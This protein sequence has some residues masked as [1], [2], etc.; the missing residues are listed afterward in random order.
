M[1]CCSYMLRD[2]NFAL[3]KG[4]EYSEEDLKFPKSTEAR[5]LL[6]GSERV[7]AALMLLGLFRMAFF[8]EE[9]EVEE[10]RGGLGVVEN[11]SFLVP[12]ILQKLK[13]LLLG[14][15]KLTSC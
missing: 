2:G 10:K 9:L 4:Q 13:M 6:E 11:D 12:A 8:V 1:V 3:Q 14:G 7:N 15:V 5:I